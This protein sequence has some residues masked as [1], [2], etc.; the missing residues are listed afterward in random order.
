MTTL[1]EHRRIYVDRFFV[2]VGKENNED[3]TIMSS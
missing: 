2:F 3:I 1:D